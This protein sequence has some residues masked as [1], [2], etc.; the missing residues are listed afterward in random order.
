MDELKQ[1]V[2]SL[3]MELESLKQ[4]FYRNNFSSRQ[5]FYKY[6]DFKTTLKVPNYSATPSTC[7]VG[8]V[9][10]VSGKLY[11]CSTANNWQIVG[12]QS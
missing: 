9:I 10:E 2:N 3:K 12:V 1:Q 8:E 6:S 4:E 11:I 7:K 5:D